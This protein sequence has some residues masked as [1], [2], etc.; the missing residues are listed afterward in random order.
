[1]LPIYRKVKEVIKRQEK[2]RR[3]NRLARNPELP[4]IDWK[5]LKPVECPKCYGMGRSVR[6][7]VC[8][9]CKGNGVVPGKEGGRKG[10]LSDMHGD[11]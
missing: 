2:A 6:E 4:G 8:V 10:D 1:M 11:G 5:P 3:D 9:E 7:G